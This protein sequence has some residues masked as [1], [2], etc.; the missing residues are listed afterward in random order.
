M[1]LEPMITIHVARHE[2][3]TALPVDPLD[4]RAVMLANFFESDIQASLTQTRDW[5][6]ALDRVERKEM[7][8]AEGTGNAFT[9]SIREDGVTLQN[10]VFADEAP[11][12]YTHAEIRAALKSAETALSKFSR[13]A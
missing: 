9:L 6:T 1:D 12:R 5:L 2:P 7:E 11:V 13:Q 8:V 4:P 3:L 10:E